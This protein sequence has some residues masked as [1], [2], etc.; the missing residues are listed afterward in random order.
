VTLEQCPIGGINNSGMFYAFNVCASKVK[1]SLLF[2]NPSANVPQTLQT[3]YATNVAVPDVMRINWNDP[4]NCLQLPVSCKSFSWNGES[5]QTAQGQS[6]SLQ[7][8]LSQN[9][10]NGWAFNNGSATLAAA[11]LETNPT[12]FHTTYCAI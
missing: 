12:P 1:A 6:F 4:T 3:Y 9:A 7:S 5:S 10:T 8:Y 11:V 2:M